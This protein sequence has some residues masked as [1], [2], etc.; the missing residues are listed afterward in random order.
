MSTQVERVSE[1]DNEAVVI[2]DEEELKEENHENH[3]IHHN[4]KIK[5]VNPQ[6]SQ[7]PMK[8]ELTP[9]DFFF[10]I[11]LGEGA[12]ARVVHAKSKKTG[13]EFA[14]K[15]MDKSHIKRENKVYF[16]RLDFFS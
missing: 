5:E 12:Y 13:T 7:A 14:I 8:I 2:E 4:H 15:I 3:H 16:F 10:G 9:S 6:P 11:T 1:D